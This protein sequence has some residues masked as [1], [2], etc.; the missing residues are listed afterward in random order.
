MSLEKRGG[1]IEYE[2]TIDDPAETGLKGHPT[3][4]IGWVGIRTIKSW[5]DNQL[6]PSF[7]SNFICVAYGFLKN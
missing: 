2:S 7:I 1:T 6:S 5:M 4:G 3:I